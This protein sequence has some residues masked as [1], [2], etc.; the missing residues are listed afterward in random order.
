[1]HN[2]RV[3]TSPDPPADLLGDE[4]AAL[5]RLVY[6]LAVRVTRLLYRHPGERALELENLVLRTQLVGFGGR[7]GGRSGRNDSE[8]GTGSVPREGCSP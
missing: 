3:R 2:D 6:P 5:D 8:R 4:S 7:S 1:M